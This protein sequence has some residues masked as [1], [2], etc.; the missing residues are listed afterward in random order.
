MDQPCQPVPVSET[1]WNFL[2][3]L[4]E[5]EDYALCS[6]GGEMEGINDLTDD[7]AD[8][9]TVAPDDEEMLMQVLASETPSVN[10]DLAHPTEDS[11]DVN[12][13]LAHPTEDSTHEMTA[14]S[15]EV[16]G[17]SQFEITPVKTGRKRRKN[18]E[19]WKRN[20]AKRRRNLGQSYV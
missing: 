17:P 1:D 13:D 6:V 2:G 18:E 9:F 8:E 20:K 3:M 5:E 14:E 4:H 12:L 7:G 16:E 11:T 19:L 10:L 15:Y